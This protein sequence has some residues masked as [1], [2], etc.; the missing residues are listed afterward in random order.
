MFPVRQ[1]V[2]GMMGLEEKTMGIPEIAQRVR[3]FY[4]QQNLK[5]SALNAGVGTGIQ[6]G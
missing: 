3:G 1:K 4:A 2:P 5:A 6:L